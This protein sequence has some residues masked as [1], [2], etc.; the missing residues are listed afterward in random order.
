MHSLLD[1][2]DRIAGRAQAGNLW[3]LDHL[4][5]SQNYVFLML[6]TDGKIIE[7]PQK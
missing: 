6:V 5:Y 1:E 4:Q 3:F 2:N 7:S